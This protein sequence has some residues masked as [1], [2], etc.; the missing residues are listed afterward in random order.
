MLFGGEYKIKNVKGLSA[1]L[2]VAFDSGS[3]LGA[4]CGIM[5][6]VQ[7]NGSLSFRSRK[8]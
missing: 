3:L 8:N 2:D 4:K 7:Y 1:T 6:G 5:A